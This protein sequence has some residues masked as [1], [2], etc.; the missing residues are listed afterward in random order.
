MDKYETRI[1]AIQRYLSGE[2][3]SAIARSYRK[4]RAWFY[5]WLKRYKA[6]GGQ[7]D[8]YKGQS[9]APKTKPTKV[10]SGVEKH[11]IAARTNLQQKRYSQTGAIAIQYEFMRQGLDPPPVWTINRV[12]ARH[13]L[14][15]KPSYAYKRSNKEYP[16]LF[17]HKHQLDLIGPR[18][19]KGD[20]RY[21]TVNIIDT[22][23][24]SVFVKPVRTKSTIEVVSALADFW[25]SHG[26]P[27]C[28]QLDNELAFRGSNRYPRSFGAVVR[29]ALSLNVAPV[30][31]PVAEPWR[32]G[33][34]EKFNHTVEKR[35]LR[36][37]IFNG[38]K[39][40]SQKSPEFVAFHNACH[41]YSSQGHKTP[42]QMREYLGPLDRYDR[43]MDLTKRIPLVT[44]S[45][46][47]V[48]FI[49][50]DLMLTLHA[51][52]FKVKENLRYSYVV[53]EV[54]VDNHCLLIRQNNEI[55][56][57]FP[58]KVPVD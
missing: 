39:H 47:F 19:L 22:E 7:G 34:I 54:N 58:F 28:L 27:D 21:Y 3:I 55:V 38:F 5:K 29:F 46:Y 25:S 9:K 51:E 2:K 43:S 26:M 23:C 6:S 30:F 18:Y 33:V 57:T 4:S 50:S 12:L 14:N 56:Q 53:A 35:F 48:R 49:R 44:G 1:Q 13:G 37:L 20:G 32:N 17:I 24:H 31:I 8:W 10:C 15:K 41:R 42:N 52:Q 36:A 11:I 45:I 16:D 40:L